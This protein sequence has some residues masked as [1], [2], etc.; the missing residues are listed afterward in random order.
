MIVCILIHLVY[1]LEITNTRVIKLTFMLIISLWYL[2]ILFINQI[3]NNNL[4]RS[5]MEVSL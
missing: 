3:I 4:R 2:T 5:G 1:H